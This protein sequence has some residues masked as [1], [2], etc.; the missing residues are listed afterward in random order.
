M[1]KKAA[2]KAAKKPAKKPA[3]AGGKK[4]FIAKAPIRRLMKTEGADLVSEDALSFLIANVEKQ[5]KAVTKAAIARVKDDKR[6]KITA[7]DVRAA[8]P[9][10]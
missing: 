9:Y 8:A 6:K 1:A 2:K 3:S 4:S 10:L 7:E 5:A